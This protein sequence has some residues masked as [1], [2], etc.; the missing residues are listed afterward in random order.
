MRQDVQEMSLA[1]RAFW[2]GLGDR[3]VLETT[4]RGPVTADPGG[5]RFRPDYYDQPATPRGGQEVA[6]SCG[7]LT[8]GQLHYPDRMQMRTGA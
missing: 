8:L 3:I 7:A 6:T 4:E 1:E 5:Q 2:A